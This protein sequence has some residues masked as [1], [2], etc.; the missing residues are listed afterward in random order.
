MRFLYTFNDDR[1]A[2]ILSTFLAQ[3]GI[4][5][6]LDLSV[7][8]DWGSAEYGN[9][10]GKLWIIE[11]DNL[12]AANKWLEIFLNNPNDPQ[13]VHSKAL[14]PHFLQEAEP[15]TKQEP[16]KQQLFRIP[17]PEYLR[18]SAAGGW[19]TIYLILGCTLLFFLSQATSPLY[20]PPPISLPPTPL[21]SSPIKKAMFYD[22]P[23]AYILIDKIIQVYGL[24]KLYNPGQ[25]PPEGR[26]LLRE[27]YHTPY[28]QGIY[29]KIV[30]YLKNPGT[31]IA[32][33]APMFEKIK[34]GQ[35]WRLFTPC[36]L[37]NDLFHLF[38]NMIW[39]LV[40]GKQVES[41]IQIG[42]YI[43][44]LMIAGIVSNTAQYLMSGANF[45]GFSGILCAMITFVWFRQKLAPWEGYQLLPVTMTFI[46]IF[47]LAMVG[48]Q[49][50]SFFL[51]IF[52]RTPITPAIANT[53]H[54][55]GAVCGIILAR[56]KFFAWQP[57]RRK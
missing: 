25:L 36:L 3:E 48:I 11:E 56:V 46:T 47:V 5:N 4:E 12:E 1:Q 27:F 34:Q 45:I 43:A 41:K 33:D 49:L 42:R 14:S 44:F 30:N 31:P 6:Q 57:K 15:K 54:L 9:V 38:F 23:Y 40:L 19:L 26:Y 32:F 24:E 7:N 18:R 51:E 16:K 2:R 52:N 20:E 10:L 37:H 21:F 28:W 35:Y 53:A 29:P 17:P 13:F 8:R 50:L 22:Y 39:L 55:T